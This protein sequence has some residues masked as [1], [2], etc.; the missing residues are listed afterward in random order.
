MENEFSLNTLIYIYIVVIRSKESTYYCVLYNDEHH[1]Y[2]HVIYT[3][4]RAIN[5]NHS[6]AHA[7]TALIDKEVISSTHS[8]VP[9]NVLVFFC[10]VFLKA[11]KCQGYSHLFVSSLT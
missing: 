9:L 4:Q 5:C 11:G 3:L 8:H 10:F 2:D 6:E 1:S 7:H